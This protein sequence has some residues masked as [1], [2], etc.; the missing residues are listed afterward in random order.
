MAAR[1]GLENGS[2]ADERAPLLV[3]QRNEEASATASS[4][5]DEEVTPKPESEASR[6]RAYGWRG[7]WIVVAILI[8]AVFVKGWIEADDVDVSN[9][10]KPCSLDTRLTN[11][12]SST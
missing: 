7:F 2:T 9:S 5:D 12:Y 6:R 1:R 11:G 10:V 8:I 3:P 4:E